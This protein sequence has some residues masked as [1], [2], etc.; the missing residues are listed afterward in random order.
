M[1]RSVRDQELN[2]VVSATRERT[3]IMPTRI[4]VILL[5][6]RRFIVGRSEHVLVLEVLDPIKRWVNR[7]ETF[8]RFRGRD[9]STVTARG[10]PEIH[11]R[12]NH[13]GGD[14][15][16]AIIEDDDVT[17]SVGGK[18]SR[19][20]ETGDVSRSNDRVENAYVSVWTTITELTDLGHF[21]GDHVNATR[22]KE[23]QSVDVT[24]VFEGLQ[25]GV[26]DATVGERSVR[27]GPMIKK[28]LFLGVEHGRTNFNGTSLNRF[29]TGEALTNDVVGV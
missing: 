11:V 1:V 28:R 23:G 13:I 14:V 20:R 5:I 26:G 25:D 8:P 9:K 15:V 3:K 7:T 29:E 12:S 24:V 17:L 6:G 16:E 21:H 22:Q 27:D 10:V 19:L 2:V 18:I 4:P